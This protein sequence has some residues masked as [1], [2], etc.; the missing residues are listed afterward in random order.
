MSFKLT[1]EPATFPKALNMVLAWYKCR[2]RLVF[3]DDMS[4]FL[5]N[6]KDHILHV[7]V[8]LMDL[9]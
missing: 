6:M 4:I 7:D 3:V 9:R 5:K 1:N 2:I 8:I